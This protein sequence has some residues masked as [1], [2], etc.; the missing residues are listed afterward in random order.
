MVVVSIMFNAGNCPIL[1]DLTA[2]KSLL[3]SVQEEGK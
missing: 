1:R 2:L 3:H